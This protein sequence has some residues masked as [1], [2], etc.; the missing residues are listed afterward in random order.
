VKKDVTKLVSHLQMKDGHFVGVLVQ[1]FVRK[2]LVLV[3]M[4][5]ATVG[6]SVLVKGSVVTVNVLEVV[7]VLAIQ[8]AGNVET[9]ITV[10]SVRKLVHHISSMTQRDISGFQTQTSSLLMAQ[11]VWIVVHLTCLLT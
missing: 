5:L 8:N 9:L 1:N 11:N 4:K 2:L 7:M 3:V 6:V 10:G